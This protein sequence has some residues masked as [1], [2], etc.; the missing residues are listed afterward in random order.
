M[1]TLSYS[2]EILKVTIISLISLRQ[3][4]ANKGLFPSAPFAIPSI[5]GFV[6]PPPYEQNVD[7]IFCDCTGKCFTADCACRKKNKPCG[8]KCH[9]SKINKNCT[10]T[11]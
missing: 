7:E 8:P 10:N 6:Q 4:D 1:L 9:S 11:K 3:L 2:M 5:Y